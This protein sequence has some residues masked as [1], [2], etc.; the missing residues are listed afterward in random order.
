VVQSDYQI[1]D[2][3]S[4]ILPKTLHLLFDQVLGKQN[5]LNLAKTGEYQIQEWKRL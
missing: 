4:G 3:L 1:Y 5:W 2:N